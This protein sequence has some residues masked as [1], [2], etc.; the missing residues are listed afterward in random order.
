MLTLF[1]GVRQLRV[2]LAQCVNSACTADVDEGQSQ[3]PPPKLAA[4]RSQG[5]DEIVDR[6]V[7]T[8]NY[9]TPILPKTINTADIN[10]GQSQGPPP[11]TCYNEVMMTGQ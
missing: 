11:K 10:E 2:R 3:G 1:P 7:V 4:M 6:V 9:S 5:H 8:T